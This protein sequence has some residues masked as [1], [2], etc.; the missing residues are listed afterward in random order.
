MSLRL[1]TSEIGASERPARRFYLDVA[2]IAAIMAVIAI[3]NWSLLDVLQIGTLRWW[4]VDAILSASRW[5]VPI[6]VMIS[7]GLLLGPRP[8]EDTS[9]F[10]RRRLLRVGVP[11]LFW[12]AAYF[13]FRATYLH[14]DLTIQTI[15]TDLALA[16]PFTQMYF[17]YVIVGLYLVTPLLRPFTAYASRSQLSITAG[18]LLG[19]WAVDTVLSY[20][21][22]AGTRVTG[23]TYWVPFLGFYIAGRALNGLQLSRRTSVLMALGILVLV[24]GQIV[25]V[26]VLAQAGDGSWQLYSQSYW[27]VFVIAAAMLIYALSARDTPG[28]KRSDLLGHWASALA[29]ATYGVFLIHEMLL[30]WHAR[31]FVTGSPA[32]LVTSRIPTYLFA[33]I[34]SF[35]IVLIVRR[36]R[37]LGAIF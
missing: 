6:F 18:A 36:I 20:A 13:V 29:G 21:I 19:I 31:T 22:D 14:Q 23:L 33:L 8:G 16:Q 2:R 12:I 5:A 9:T 30:Y 24:A 7:G 37:R 25:T 17:V 27:S 3:H 4:A 32:L 1:V 15:V 26:F 34:G 28:Q 35:L 11:A 10:Y